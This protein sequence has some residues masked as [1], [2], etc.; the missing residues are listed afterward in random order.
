MEDLALLWRKARAA[1]LGAPLILLLGGMGAGHLTNRALALPAS[2]EV[3]PAGSLLVP[4]VHIDALSSR[5]DGVRAKGVRTA[6]IVHFYRTD[7]EP[8]ERVLRRR[9]V[10]VTTARLV[11]WPLVEHS[12]QNRLDLAMVISV[13][14]NESNGRP[15]ARSSVGARGLM[16]VMPAWSGYWKHCGRNLYDIDANLCNGTSIL[17]YY[18]KQHRGDQRRALLGYNGCVRG[19]NTPNCHTYP[20]KIERLRRQIAAEL[21]T[22]RTESSPGIAASR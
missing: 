19:A 13:M 18:L 5:L 20:D 3:R 22:A 11:A 2:A 10:K 4:R 17:A 6:D 16:Q 1:L 7:I 15:D 12:A 21:A 8:V 14:F 9:G